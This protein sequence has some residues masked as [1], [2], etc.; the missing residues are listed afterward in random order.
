MN[1]SYWIYIIVGGLVLVV[2]WRL[3]RKSLSNIVDNALKDKDIQPILQAIES[4][5]G[6]S[7]P[8]GYNLAIRR[9]WDSYQRSLAIELVVEL[10]K[11]HGDEKIAQYWL[12]QVMT[13]EPKMAQESFSKEF[14]DAYYK[15]EVAAQCGK[16]G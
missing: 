8:N 1:T 14:L 4:R 16:V 12:K 6:D 15:P 2:F 9:L 11:K 3:S 13:V 5:S 10:A 7:Q